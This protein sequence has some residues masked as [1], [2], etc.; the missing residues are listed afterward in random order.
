V[1]VETFFVFQD[2]RDDIAG[3][4]AIGARGILV[5]TGKYRA[6]DEN[7]ISPPPAFVCSSFPEA[8]DLIVEKISKES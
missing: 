1:P 5:K 6:G 7:K 3:A 2:V 4:Q 8:V